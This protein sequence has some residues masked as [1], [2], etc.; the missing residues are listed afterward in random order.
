MVAVHVEQIEK[1]M[2]ILDDQVRAGKVLYVGVSDWSAEGVRPG[3]H[4]RVIAWV[5]PI[6]RRAAALQRAGPHPERDLLTMAQ[7]FDLPVF[8]WGPLAGGRRP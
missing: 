5:A 6:R 8:V 4:P 7:A 2:R 1:I 3:E